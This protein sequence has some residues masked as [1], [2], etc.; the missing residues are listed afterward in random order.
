MLRFTWDPAK[1]E[2]NL[3]KHGISFDEARTV[4][5]DP[6]NADMSD[7][8]HSENE[9]RFVTIGK[10]EKNQLLVVVY[11]E[12]EP[13]WIHIISA[14]RTTPSERRKYEELG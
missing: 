9:L 5:G 7:P 6:L 10:S 1:A 11:A 4:F 13:D 12:P 3:R 8:D 2:W 14:R